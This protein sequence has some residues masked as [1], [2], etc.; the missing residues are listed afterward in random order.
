MKS[1]AENRLLDL[2][3]G[4]PATGE[5]PPALRRCRAAESPDLGECIRF[6]ESLPSNKSSLADVR[7][8]CGYVPF[9]LEPPFSTGTGSGSDKYF[10][11]AGRHDGSGGCVGIDAVLGGDR[12]QV[13]AR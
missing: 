8:S 11:L 6:L 2:D 3:K 13:N 7:E 5:D 4:L 10:H 1:R 12:D 9:E